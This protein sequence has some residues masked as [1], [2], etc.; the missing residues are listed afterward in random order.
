MTTSDSPQSIIAALD[1]PVFR[2]H[3]RWTI[4]GAEYFAL[5]GHP[6]LCLSRSALSGALLGRKTAINSSIQMRSG[7]SFSR[8]PSIW[9]CANALQ[10]PRLAARSIMKNARGSS[11]VPAAISRRFYPA[12]NSIVAPAGPASGNRFKTLSLSPPTIRWRWNVP[13]CIAAAAAAISDMCSATVP[14]RQA[15]AIASMA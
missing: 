8:L 9:C 3:R 15:C 12:R 7:Q 11:T 2:V 4:L 6:R 13:K 1:N 10:N 14:S 5:P